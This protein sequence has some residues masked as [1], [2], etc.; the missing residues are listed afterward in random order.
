MINVYL[1]GELGRSIGE[2]WLL[3]VESTQEA[4]AAIDANGGGIYEFLSSNDRLSDKYVVLVDNEDIGEEDLTVKRARKEIHI[5]PHVA[6]GKKA[7]KFIFAIALVVAGFML[8]GPTNPLGAALISAG[9]GLAIQGVIELL[10]K[11]PKLEESKQTQSYLQDGNVNN[12]A[13]GQ[14]V[15]VGYGRLRVGSQVIGVNQ[16]HSL[17]QLV[18][19][20]E[21]FE[22]NRLSSWQSLV[23]DFM[24]FT[25]ESFEGNQNNPEEGDP[26][27]NLQLNQFRTSEVPD[28]ARTTWLN[29]QVYE[30]D[31]YGNVTDNWKSVDL[32]YLYSN[33][34]E[35]FDHTQDES[36]RALFNS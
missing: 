7:F 35:N 3:D 31:L 28:F 36:Y 30:R 6:G 17:K 29:A 4:I 16:R 34:P 8:G 14:S 10:T 20:E 26:Q 15:P 25:K 1:H 5:M 18:T 9:I 21:E 32:D 23:S 27:F 24:V 22:Y 11:P 13:Q 33:I 2:K 12:A 19:A